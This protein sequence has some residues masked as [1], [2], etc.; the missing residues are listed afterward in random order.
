MPNRLPFLNW[1]FYHIYNR[2]FNKQLTFKDAVDYNTFIYLW[3]YFYCEKDT[4]EIVSYCL[5]PNHFHFLIKS[6]TDWFSISCFLQKVCSNYAKYFI[7]KYSLAKGRRLFEWRF[8]SKILLTE[9]Y[10]N[11]CMFYI[12]FN[13]QKH[14]YV[15]DVS[16]WK[17]CSYKKFLESWLFNSTGYFDWNS[18]IFEY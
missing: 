2:W 16:F 12:N 9:K 5:L 8:R 3:D 7:Y 6:L 14:G 15:D 1:C 18:D 4:F 17:Y 13:A 11:Q 10:V